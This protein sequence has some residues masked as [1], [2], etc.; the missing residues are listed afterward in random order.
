LQD[1]DMTM[2][3]M[4]LLDQPESVRVAL[5]PLRRQLLERLRTPASATQLAA[6]LTLGRQRV[7][8][9]LRAL[10]E[11]G[12]IELVEERQRR[13]CVER[14]LAARARAFVVDPSVMGAPER[15]AVQAAAQD[16]FAAD[17]LINSAA[18]IVRDV[19]RMQARAAQQGTRLLT[20]TIDTDISFATPNDLEHFTTAL[21]DFVARQAA[22]YQTPDGGRRYRVVLSGHPAP[23]RAVSPKPSTTH[24]SGARHARAR[25][26]SRRDSHRRT[27]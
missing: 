24:P 27:H 16:R 12:L 22:Q 3:P 2:A 4:A 25:S 8:Y 14:I 21:A 26:R 19:A 13:G 20:F 11:A 10:E 23:T 15:P 6:E 5:S 7:N 1:R 17:H 9:H 18:A